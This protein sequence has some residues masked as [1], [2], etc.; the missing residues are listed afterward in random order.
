MRY[1]IFRISLLPLTFLICSIAH[2]ILDNKISTQTSPTI[3]WNSQC[4]RK[5]V[6]R[7]AISALFWI[8]PWLSNA[9]YS[10]L[11]YL[12]SNLANSPRTGT[13]CFNYSARP[14]SSCQS[15]LTIIW[16]RLTPNLTQGDKN[17]LFPIKYAEQLSS[18]LTGVRDGAILYSV[19][20]ESI[21][22][23]LSNLFQSS[24]I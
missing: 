23:L 10:V 2:L 4:S 16:Y 15:L 20:G 19:K 7:R 18:Q 11:F 12:C 22:R 14:F 5:C 3:S 9:L 13:M 1:D 6:Y 21:H 8:S 17:E 24:Y